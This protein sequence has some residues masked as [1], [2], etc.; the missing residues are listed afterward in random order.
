MRSVGVRELREKTSEIVRGVREKGEPVDITHRGKV[1][2]RIVPIDPTRPDPQEVAAWWARWDVL[3][4]EISKH[5]PEGV[6]A[7]DAIREQRR[8]L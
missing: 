1:V 7:V 6:S 4:K 2:A 8:E 5:W 3:A